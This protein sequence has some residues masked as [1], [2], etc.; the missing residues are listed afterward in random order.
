M[1]TPNRNHESEL[2]GSFYTHT[3][4]LSL[5]TSLSLCVFVCLHVC[6]CVCVCVCLCVHVMVC[7]CACMCMCVCV[8]FHAYGICK[9]INPRVCTH[10]HI[11][12]HR[13][14]ITHTNPSANS[15]IN[16][17]ILKVYSVACLHVTFVLLRTKHTYVRSTLGNHFRRGLVVYLVDTFTITRKSIILQ[18][19]RA[20]LKRKNR[21]S[22]SSI[23]H[24]SLATPIHGSRKRL[25]KHNSH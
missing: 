11:G 4:S 24:H 12:M 25:Q 2:H 3:L 13:N 22:M 17:H 23:N 5:S 21:E 6:V 19:T 16:Q 1:R 10:M 18:R 14:H 15:E 20:L 7:A 9:H 8:C